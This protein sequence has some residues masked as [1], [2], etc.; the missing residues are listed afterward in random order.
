M[1]PVSPRR[2]GRQRGSELLEATFILIPMI[3]YIFLIL[4]ITLMVWVKGTLQFAV[5]GGLR[6]G[7]ASQVWPGY[8]DPE[9]SIKQ[10]VKFLAMGLMNGKNPDPPDGDGKP[11]LDKIV[12]SYWKRGS[13]GTFT[14]LAIRPDSSDIP[15]T[16]LEVAIQDYRWSMIA[17]FMRPAGAMRFDA[18]SLGR[19]E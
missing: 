15:G 6:Y 10:D 8:A 2:A 19:M 16:I 18:H 13:D 4:D 11:Y 12:I 3:G 17:P 1:R 9:D 14:K 7:I 5:E